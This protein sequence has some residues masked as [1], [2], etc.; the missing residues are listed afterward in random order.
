[1]FYACALDLL[2][3]A[4]FQH[5]SVL[6]AQQRL[7]S[8]IAEWKIHPPTAEGRQDGLLII[9]A[10]VREVVAALRAQRML[11]IDMQRALSALQANTEQS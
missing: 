2:A 7:E 6:D 10:K 1:M 5:R 3:Q 11:A 4:E 8:C 9:A